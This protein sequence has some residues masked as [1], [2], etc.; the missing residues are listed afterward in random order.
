LQYGA[1]IERGNNERETALGYAA[2]W[3]SLAVVRMLVEAGAKVNAV[4][5]TQKDQYST[6]L[7][8]ADNR[9]EIAEYLRQKGAKR[10]N[11]LLAEQRI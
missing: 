1:D 4:G 2:S 10:W 5:G 8:A 9:R 7:E 6:I 11:E 3:A